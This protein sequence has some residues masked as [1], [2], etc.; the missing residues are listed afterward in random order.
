MQLL[1]A[2]IFNLWRIKIINNIL[3]VWLV[4]NHAYKIENKC[5]RLND[6]PDSHSTIR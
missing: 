1:T 5:R 3:S 6:V 4:P 2:T